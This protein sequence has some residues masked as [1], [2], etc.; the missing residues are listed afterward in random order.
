MVGV[1]HDH[2]NGLPSSE[3]LDRVQIHPRLNKSG[4]KC[5][6]QVME[7]SLLNT[8]LLD[9]RIKRPEEVSGT[10]PRGISGEKD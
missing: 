9:S 7:T 8:R 10:Y 5:V 1:T 6:P 2:R 3:L 4:G